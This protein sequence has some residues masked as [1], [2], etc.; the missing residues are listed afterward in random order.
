M[1]IYVIVSCPQV[2]GAIVCIHSENCIFIKIIVIYFVIF[3]CFY[4]GMAK[5]NNFFHF[6]ALYM[7][8]CVNKF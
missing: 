2:Q 1:L 4:C 8:V 7:L 3:S 6:L 5:F